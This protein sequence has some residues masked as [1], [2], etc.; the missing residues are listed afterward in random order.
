VLPPH[1]ERRRLRRQRYF[2]AQSRG[3][4]DRC[5]RFTPCGHPRACKTRLPAACQALPGRIWATCEGQQRKVSDSL[6]PSSFPRLSLAL[7]AETRPTECASPPRRL[8]AIPRTP[9]PEQ[10]FSCGTPRRES[11]DLFWAAARAAQTTRRRVRVRSSWGMRAAAL[12]ALRKKRDLFHRVQ[13]NA[14]PA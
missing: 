6:D 12:P 3:F 11:P 7:S 13:Q 9:E 14:L 10:R 1:A 2:G 4:G 5:L 8:T